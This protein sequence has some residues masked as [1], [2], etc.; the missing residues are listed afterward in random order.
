MNRDWIPLACLL[1]GIVIGSII[2]SLFII[3]SPSSHLF[4]KCP[5]LKCEKCPDC[6]FN[7]EKCPECI[8]NDIPCECN[9]PNSQLIAENLIQEIKYTHEY[10]CDEYSWELVRR[11]K[12]AGYETEYCEGYIN[13]CNYVN[14]R[15]AW[16]KVCQYVEATSGEFITPQD[17]SEKYS[18]SFCTDD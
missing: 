3:N 8:H 13:P 17:F 11:Y 2:T 10:N 12:N 5:D 6:I 16:V 15:H 14:C 9:K 7:D 18:K 1:I 4:Y